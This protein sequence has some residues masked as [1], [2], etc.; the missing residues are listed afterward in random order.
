LAETFGA[1]PM[2]IWGP[3]EETLAA[4]VRRS[5][6]RESLLAPPTSI[7]ELAHLLSK[8][9]A[10]VGNDSGPM[11]IAAAAGIGVVGL[12]GPTDPKRVAPW[13]PRTRA[14]EP[15]EPFSKKRSVEGLS[16]D[17]VYSAAAELLE[18]L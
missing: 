1:L 13:T 17:Q 10:Y 7:K 18:R 3:G 14:V 5:M 16:V 11:H 8:C 6:K 2:V 9:A 15:F 12:F 4:A